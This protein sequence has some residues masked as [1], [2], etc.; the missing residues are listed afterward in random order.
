MSN[1]ERV[2][3]KFCNYNLLRLKLERRIEREERKG[4]EKG[5]KKIEK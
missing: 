1:R 2:S 3:S 4:G 5:R